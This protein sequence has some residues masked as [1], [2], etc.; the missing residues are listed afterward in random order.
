MVRNSNLSRFVASP[1][2]IDAKELAVG[3]VPGVEAQESETVTVA[4]PLYLSENMK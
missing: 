1:G 3:Y 2:L 4:S